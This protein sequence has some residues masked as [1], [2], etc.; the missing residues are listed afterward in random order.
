[1]LPATRVL[2][3]AASSI[4]PVSVVV[5]DF[6]LVPVMAITRP[7]SQREASSSSPIIGMPAR[8]AF[9]R[10]RDSIGTPGLNTIRSALSNRAGS[11]PPVSTRIPSDSS[12]SRSGTDDR[13]SLTV[14]RA[15]LAASSSAAATPLRAAPPT[16][17]RCPSTENSVP[18]RS[19]QL[20]RREREEREDDSD[21]HEARDDLRLAPPDQ[22]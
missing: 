6:P 22:L 3:P 8:R 12:R 2:K 5:V 10:N 4:R 19:P 7:R 15:P 21:D 9:C 13:A 18:I 1:M 11:F 20:Q 16:V 17:T 14:T